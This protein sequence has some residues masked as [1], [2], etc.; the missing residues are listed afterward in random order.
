MT[1]LPELTFSNYQYFKSKNGSAHIATF[2]SQ[3]NLVE[4][5]KSTECNSIL[6][7]GSGIG[8][9]AKLMET[10]GIAEIF[11]FE[12]SEW[13]KE[14]AI[15]NLHPTTPQYIYELTGRVGF[16]AVCIDDE[17][18]RKQISQMLKEKKLRVIF[19]E[20]WRNKTASQVSRRLF[21]HGYTA[22]FNRGAARLN[23]E[24]TFNKSLRTQEKAG[25]WFIIEKQSLHLAFLSWT[26][27]VSRTGEFK[28]LFKEFYFWFRRLLSVRMRLQQYSK[29]I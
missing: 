15:N 18:S 2:S 8:T 6:D 29:G 10:I 9:V 1:S 27:R 4:L 19:I 20:G 12:R 26:R 7:Y 13:C 23:S 25:C 24:W 17:I 11:C 5:L 28:E 21:V 22:T 16:E 14:Q 3:L